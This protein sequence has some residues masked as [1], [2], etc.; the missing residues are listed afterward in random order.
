M[1]A[2]AKLRAT[3]QQPIPL[4]PTLLYEDYPTTAVYIA[5]L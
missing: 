4:K 2:V 1:A 5:K 3:K